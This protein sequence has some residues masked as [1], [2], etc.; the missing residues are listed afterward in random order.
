MAI[1]LEQQNKSSTNWVV[2]G[3]V[4][5]II[6]VLFAGLYF[7]FFQRPELVDVA[8]PGQFKELK[9]LSGIEFKPKEIFESEKFKNLKQ[10]ETDSSL[11]EPG[12]D[13]PFKSF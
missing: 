3:S 8:V 4:F 10:I 11:P 12:R 9:K 6:L 1:E 7:V 13:N 5:V 2:V